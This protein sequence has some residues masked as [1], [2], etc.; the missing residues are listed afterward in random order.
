M[1]F[2]ASEGSNNRIIINSLGRKIFAKSIRFSSRTG[3]R[4]QKLNVRLEIAE[5]GI[6]AQA[7]RSAPQWDESPKQHISFLTSVFCNTAISNTYGSEFSENFTQLHL[8]IEK[9]SLFE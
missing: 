6:V 7:G 3:E 1:S 8:P 2:F 4:L 5:V 9:I